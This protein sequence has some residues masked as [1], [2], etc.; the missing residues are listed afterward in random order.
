MLPACCF[1]LAF[2]KQSYSA[3]S[4]LSFP[5]YIVGIVWTYKKALLCRAYR[6]AMLFLID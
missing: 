5:P 4:F 2:G 6:A 1:S 3:G